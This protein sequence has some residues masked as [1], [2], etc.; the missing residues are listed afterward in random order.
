MKPTYIVLDK[1]KGICGALCDIKQA[2][3]LPKDKNVLNWLTFRSEGVIVWDT[4]KQ[5]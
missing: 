2:K 3:T 5:A 1:Q 4:Y